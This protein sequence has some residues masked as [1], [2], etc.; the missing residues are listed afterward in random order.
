MTVLAGSVCAG[1]LNDANRLLES[2]NYPQALQLYARLSSAGNAEAQ[3]HL[4]EMYWYGEGVGADEGKAKDLFEKAAGAGNKGATGALTVM[5]QRVAHKAEIAFYTNKYDGAD[6]AL[7]KFNCGRPVIPELSKN[8]KDIAAVAQGVKDWQ[9]CYNG[10]VAN[11]NASLPPGKAIPPAIAD[12]M[13][14]PEYEMAK[15]RMDKA[16]AAVAA[17]AKATSDQILAENATW[18]DKTADYVKLTNAQ[19]AFDKAVDDREREQMQHGARASG[20]MLTGFGH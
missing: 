4:G 20:G 9:S 15:A 14:G 5:Q 12:L 10:F 11:L 6:V 17:Q 1:E 16:Y 19:I 18:H 8:S 7:G 13:N 2:K 3:F